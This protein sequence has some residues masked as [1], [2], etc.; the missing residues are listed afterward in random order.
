M[1]EKQAL[2]EKAAKDIKDKR[3][4][5]IEEDYTNT[6]EQGGRQLHRGTNTTKVRE[7]EEGG[8]IGAESDGRICWMWSVN[9][10]RLGRVTKALVSVFEAGSGR[11]PVGCGDA[12]TSASRLAS[13]EEQVPLKVAVMS[14]RD[15]RK[16]MEWP[17]RLTPLGKEPRTFLQ[18]GRGHE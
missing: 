9:D 14:F 8:N 12:S 16:R 1:E 6:Q 10:S 4:K 15:E 2:L 17:K 11:G 3:M 13:E 5:R 18:K 7:G